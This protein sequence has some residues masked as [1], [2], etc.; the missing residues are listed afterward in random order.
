MARIALLFATIGA[1]LRVIIRRLLHGPRRPSWGLLFEI[2]VNIAG[3]ALARVTPGIG[4]KDPRNLP[5]E[6]LNAIRKATSPPAGAPNPI[7]RR[8]TLRSVRAG[9]CDGTWITPKEGTSGRDI[10]YLHGGGYFTCSVATHLELMARL[11][12]SCEARV[13]GLAYRLAPENPFPAALDDAVAAWRWLQEQG[14]EPGQAFIAG[15][16]AGGG[17]T[18]ATLLRLRDEGGRLPAGAVLMSPWVDLAGE[19]ELSIAE[20]AEVDYLG[21]GA[22]LLSL[23]GRLYAGEAPLDGPLVSP[24]HA[25]HQ[26]LPPLLVQSGEAEILRDQI[27]GFVARARRA[28]VDVRHDVWPDMVHVFQAFSLVCP[29]GRLAIDEA[30]VWVRGASA[31]AASGAGTMC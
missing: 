13:L 27:A 21:P 6:D 29:D 24:R 1:A 28:G 30:G 5:L 18:L 8:V 7:L 25:D 12:L 4:G 10:L 31:R 16:S 14:V 2:A 17:L 26:G 23:V 11:A 19:D 9:D 22:G 20:N 15:D 3:T